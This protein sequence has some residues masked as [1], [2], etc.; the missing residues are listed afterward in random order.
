MKIFRVFFK[1]KRTCDNWRPQKKTKMSN[2]QEMLT[3]VE[4][5]GLQGK[6]AGDFIK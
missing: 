4:Q 3:M 1:N 2:L 5:I 6:E